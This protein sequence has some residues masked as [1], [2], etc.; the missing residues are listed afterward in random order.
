MDSL[1]Y[2]CKRDGITSEVMNSINVATFNYVKVC[3]K[4]KT[5]RYLSMTKKYLKDKDL[6]A[7]P[8]DKGIGIC[9]MKKETY[10]AKMSDLL[11]LDYI[12][13]WIKPR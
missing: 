10:E 1:L 7:I 2:S 11:E 12:K 5:P 9:L 6:L 4:Q 8:F 3:S 13:K